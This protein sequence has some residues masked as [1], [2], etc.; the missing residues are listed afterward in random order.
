MENDNQLK[1]IIRWSWEFFANLRLE[2]KPLT[3]NGDGEQRRDFTYVGDVVSANIK[4]SSSDKVGNGEVLN[5]GNGDNRSV[6]DIARM[7]GGQTINC[8]PVIEPRETL[9]NN[10]RTQR[11][12]DWKPT[13][14][15]EEWMP[16]YKKSIGL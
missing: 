8:A 10:N 13:M 3:I 16:T 5:V 7:I 15:L 11:L 2:G 6:N 14:K 12:L 4:A 1:E 9:A